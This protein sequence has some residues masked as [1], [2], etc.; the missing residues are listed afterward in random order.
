MDAKLCPD[1]GSVKVNINP[2]SQTVQPGEKAKY[3]ITI[4]DKH[5]IY[6]AISGYNY[7]ITVSNLPFS[8]DYDKEVFLPPGEEARITL[9]VDT[10]TGVAVAT[11]EV[12]GPTETA[13]AGQ[14]VAIQA[15]TSASK[16]GKS[17]AIKSSASGSTSAISGGRVQ[18]VNATAAAATA[19]SGA[20][21]PSTAGGA[22]VEAIAGK[23][24]PPTITPA[25]TYQFKVLVSG[26]GAQATA[27]ATLNVRYTPPPPQE[28][29]SL[30]L[31]QGWNLISLP[32]EG[33]LSAG[34]CSGAGELYAF[35]YLE[36]EGRY[37]TLK[38][39][40]NTM[41]NEYVRLH[42]FWV[43]SFNDC[44]MEFELEK[45]TGFSELGLVEG[46]NFVPITSDMEGSSLGDIASDCS[47]EKAYYW[48]AEGQTWESLPLDRT[49]SSKMAYQGFV[50]KSDNDCDFGWGDITPPPLPE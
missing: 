14:A 26:A 13:E 40:I 28:K 32:G 22:S 33:Q 48:N 11:P 50:A 35:V 36:Y 21:Q 7:D 6:V 18:V 42:S 5:P 15:N 30:E 1:D 39:A 38:E 41:G 24:M 4:K 9:T 34:T 27:S 46:W 20:V 44:Y 3:T 19:A 47:I 43:Y 45:A 31:E 25:G 29:V 23:H 16:A 10:S 12:A 37:A 17:K 2:S 8:L 49:F